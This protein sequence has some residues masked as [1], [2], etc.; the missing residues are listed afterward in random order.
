MKELYNYLHLMEAAHILQKIIFV[1]CQTCDPSQI[2]QLPNKCL[3][4]STMDIS[5]SSKISHNLI[6]SCQG[7]VDLFSAIS[8][9][10]L[11][12]IKP[13]WQKPEKNHFFQDQFSVHFDSVSQNVLKTNIKNSKFGWFSTNL[14][15]FRPKSDILVCNLQ[16][17]SKEID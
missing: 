14:A 6:F 8:V 16:S 3:Y 1:Y 10:N 2:S 11:A 17:L 7:S 4:K 15:L 9:S 5:L 12:K 13:V